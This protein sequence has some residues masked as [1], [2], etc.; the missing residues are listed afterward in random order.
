MNLFDLETFVAVVDYGSVVGAAAGLHIT[1]SA[2]TRRLRSLEDV[3][4][5]R[6]LDRQSRPLQPT[7]AGL[8][9]YEFAK[10]VLNSVSDLKAAV[11]HNGEPSGNFRFG[12]SRGL[13]SLALTTP[14]CRLRSAYPRVKIQAFAKWTADLLEQLTNRTLDAAVILLP[15]GGS[16]PPSLQNE[17]LG[18]E[19]FAIV[20]AKA[21]RFSP[22]PTLEEL[23]S[24][25]WILNPHGCGPRRSVESALV[26]RGLPFDVAVEAEG[27]DLQMSLVSQGIGLAL[28]MPQ[29]LRA[30]SFRKDLRVI[31]V[32]EFLPE[33]T[34]WIV[35]SR[36]I[37]RLAPVVRTLRDCVRESLRLRPR[38][39]D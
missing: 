35:H 19:T 26:T 36:H 29:V 9:T 3:L 18:T 25:G 23:S 34:I 11:V 16:P 39:S 22:N 6:L 30:S 32:N 27:F 28:V 17:L 5:V 24:H 8:E 14:I 38:Q 21:R 33:Q 31:K 13:G 15:K 1:Q 4:G 12:V 20:A 37:G 2:V 10:P 7:R